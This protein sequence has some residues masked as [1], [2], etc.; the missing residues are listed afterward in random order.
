MNFKNL[1]MSASLT[2][3]MSLAMIPAAQA[4][5]AATSPHKL[6]GNI[7][8]FSKYILRGITNTPE[9]DDPAIQGGV[10]YSHASGFYAGYWGSNLGYAD[11]GKSNGFEN[12][13]YGG[14]AGSAGSFNYSLGLIKYLYVHIDNADGLE[15][16]GTAG[17]GPFTLGFK[18]LTNDVVWGNQGDTYWTL[19]YKTALPA[20]FSFG[21]TLGYYTYEDSGKYIA[22][23][24]EDS[25]FRHL[26]LNISH[27]IGNTGAAVGLTYVVGGE[28]RNGVDQDNDVV[29]NLS[30]AFDIIK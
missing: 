20:D 13:F 18:Y 16:V 14:F 15:A 9:N 7:G 2:A 11:T 24:A 28:D 19:N 30:Y 22:S 23:S 27:P 12:D 4:D 3:C 17:A 6:T 26:D 10:D 29:L 8:V 1:K 21:A 5:E 25:A